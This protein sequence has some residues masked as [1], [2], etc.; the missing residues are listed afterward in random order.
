MV[1]LKNIKRNDISISC[2][3]YLE[4]QE[5]KGFIEIRLSDGEVT[6]HDKAH[7]VAY[8]SSHVIRKLRELRTVEKLPKERTIFWY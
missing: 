8:G 6:R 7:D 2:D 5:P 3:Y 1:I 4:G